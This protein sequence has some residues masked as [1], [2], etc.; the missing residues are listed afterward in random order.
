[1]ARAIATHLPARALTYTRPHGGLYLWCRLPQRVSG[2]QLLQEAIAAGVA[3]A[4]GE[5]FYMDDTGGQELRL[6]FSNAEP[7]SIE[8][9]VRR[10]GESLRA[11]LSRRPQEGAPVLPVV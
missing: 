1:M 9:G 5:L 11:A 10:L 8:V 6:C 3:F 4:N 7:S 2:R